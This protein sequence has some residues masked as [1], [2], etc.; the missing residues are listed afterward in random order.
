[1]SLS[2]ALRPFLEAS[3]SF[4][5]K[6]AKAAKEGAEIVF[7]NRGEKSNSRPLACEALAKQAQRD[8]ILLREATD[9]SHATSATGTKEWE[10]QTLLH[11]V[12]FAP[13]HVHAFTPCLKSESSPFPESTLREPTG[14]RSNSSN[15]TG[16]RPSDQ[17]LQG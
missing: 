14:L 5:A 17:A 6:T 7:R 8:K 9:S 11:L 10:T 16:R 4:H 13:C 12:T 15:E 3:G 2:A 1:M